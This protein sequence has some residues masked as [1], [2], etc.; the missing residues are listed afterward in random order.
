MGGDVDTGNGKSK[1]FFGKRVGGP[2]LFA[3]GNIFVNL[4]EISYKNI[5]REG[6]AYGNLLKFRK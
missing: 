3:C 5:I 1:A 4:L 6:M 2:A